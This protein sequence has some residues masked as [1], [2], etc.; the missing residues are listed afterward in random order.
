[1][2][3]TV[4]S[5]TTNMRFNGA[6]GG[7]D[8]SL[9]TP[10]ASVGDLLIV[11][12]NND[13]YAASGLSL[14]SI[15]PAATA[16]EITGFETDGGTNEPHTKAWWAPVT[17]AGA[18]T[19]TCHTTGGDEE[20]SLITYVLS[21]ADTTNPID[22]AAASALTSTTT[23]MIAP[24]V[25]PTTSTALLICNIQTDS[26]TNALTMTFTAPGSMSNAYSLTDGT[27]MRTLG[28]SEILATSGA[29]GTQT[30]T[31]GGGNSTS[32]TAS[33]MAIKAAAGGGGGGGSAPVAWLHP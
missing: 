20:L 15:S 18:V 16:T 3:I 19:V 23:T 14:G 31:S 21:G 8:V 26:S 7:A 27:F 2:A 33:S 17:T 11:I 4:K 29:T 24:S 1:M 22:A 25:S 32:Y 10:A 13:F 30:W 5:V 12:F 6:L 9:T 28:A